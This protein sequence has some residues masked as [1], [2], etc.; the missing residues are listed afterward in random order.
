MILRLWLSVILPWAPA[1]LIDAGFHGSLSALIAGLA[2]LGAILFFIDM[3]A[4]A[5]GQLGR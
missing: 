5:N 3:W 2:L 4:F 1:R